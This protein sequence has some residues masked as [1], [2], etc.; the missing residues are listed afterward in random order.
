MSFAHLAIGSS[1]VEGTAAFLR[2]T[3]GYEIISPPSNTP[4]DVAWLDIS[5]ARDRSEQ[6]HVI[7]VDDF[8][9]S[10]FDQEFGRH[11]AVFHD[12]E[13]FEG[14]KGRLIEHGGELIDAI[15]PTPFER[16]FFREPVNGYLFEVVDEG[17]WKVED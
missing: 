12:G 6:I 16:F 8:E 7:R 10:R 9:I 15:R 2:D 1:D 4:R 3:L 14:L 11:F 17:G 5:K 13:D